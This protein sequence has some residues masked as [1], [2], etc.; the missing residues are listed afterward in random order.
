MMSSNN[1]IVMRRA[2]SSSVREMTKSVRVAVIKKNVFAGRFF[3]TRAAISNA[4]KAASRSTVAF[5]V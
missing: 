4:R 2:A 1:T 3:A 5:G